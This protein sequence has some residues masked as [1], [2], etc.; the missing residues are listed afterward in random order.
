[1]SVNNK[2]GL[3]ARV[4]ATAAIVT[5]LAVVTQPSAMAAAPVISVSQTSGLAD[6]QQV[7]VAATGL[8]PN[9]Q[10]TIGQCAAVEPGKFGCDKTT[11]VSVTANAQGAINSAITVHS[12]F[13]A[14]V[15]ADGTPW[16]IVDAKVTQTQIVVLSATG[17]GGSQAINFK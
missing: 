9:T 17:D 10:F 1:M 15:N 2:L 14:V 12:S 13:E 8:T 11:S 7:S 5:G 3:I 6:G 16:G 4:G